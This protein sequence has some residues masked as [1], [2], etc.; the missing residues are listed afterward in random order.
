ATSATVFLSRSSRHKPVPD[1]DSA[2][3]VALESLV[4]SRAGSRSAVASDRNRIC[5]SPHEPAIDLLRLVGKDR[6]SDEVLEGHRSVEGDRQL[7]NGKRGAAEVEKVI[8]PVDLVLGDAERLRPRSR[9]PVL[10]R[11]TRP[12]VVLLAP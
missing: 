3:S 7:Q 6:V 11:R 12:L 5:E 4:V 2:D 9:Q 10:G 8:P 1:S